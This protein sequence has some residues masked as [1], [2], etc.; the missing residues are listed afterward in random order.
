VGV[1]VVKMGK[2]REVWIEEATWGSRMRERLG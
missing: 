2:G 1:E